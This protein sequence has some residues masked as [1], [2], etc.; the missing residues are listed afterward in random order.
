MVAW[1]YMVV[2]VYGGIWW[3]GRVACWHN[4]NVGIVVQVQLGMVVGC[5]KF[6]AA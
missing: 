1:W 4:G 6:V 5:S 2:V 3:Q